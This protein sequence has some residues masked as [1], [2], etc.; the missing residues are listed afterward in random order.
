MNA[1][2][3]AV[4][5]TASTSGGAARA[6]S[7]PSSYSTAPSA[8]SVTAR[9]PSR[10]VTVS[11]S[12]RFTTVRSASTATGRAGAAL[13]QKTPVAPLPRGLDGRV[14]DL[15][16]AEDRIVL[17]KR[18]LPQVAVR[19]RR[20]DDLRLTGGVDEDQRDARRLV[21][22]CELERDAGVRSPASASS[23]IGVSTDRADHRHLRAEPR[24]RDGLVRAL[25][26]GKA[27]ERR[28]GHGLA[29]ARE[30]LAARDEVE[31][32]RPDDGDARRQ[33][34]ERA[35]VVHRRPE[36]RV[37]QVEEPGPQRRAVRS[38]VEARRRREAF[39]RA[40]EH[41][42]L[43]VD[44]GD[45]VRARAERPL[46]RGRASTRRARPLRGPRTTTGPP[47][48]PARARGGTAK[49][50]APARRAR[51]RPDPPHVG[52]PLDARRAWPGI[53][54]PLP[55]R[56]SSR[57]NASAA[58]SHARSCPTRR[59]AVSSLAA[60]PSMTVCQLTSRPR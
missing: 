41:R 23:A 8:P 37:L 21:R 18:D 56:S 25:P 24:A 32:D 53:A 29:R 51:S 45:A 20:D 52:A 33:A 3:A 55:H 31:V 49:A 13:R 48:A 54:S 4:P 59:R 35:Q 17:G 16:L 58:A 26:A 1:S 38:G 27:R 22:L 47:P 57:Q 6:T 46:G 9:S 44:R 7:S 60:F 2:P 40:H 10:R 34:G 11:S 36:E 5:S 30:A 15:Q 28:V 14:R 43:E 19:A 12:Y 39:E 42:E 50:A